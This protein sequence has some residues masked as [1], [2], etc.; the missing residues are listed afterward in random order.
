MYAV[1]TYAIK[2]IQIRKIYVLPAKREGNFLQDLEVS[3][4][5]SVTHEGM[6]EL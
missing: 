4:S 6:N 5:Y 3:H 1:C 2:D